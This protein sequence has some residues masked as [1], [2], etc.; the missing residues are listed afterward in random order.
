MKA[1]KVS[2][3]VPEGY[4]SA[5]YEEWKVA[6]QGKEGVPNCYL[7]SEFDGKYVTVWYKTTDDA[8][9]KYRIKVVNI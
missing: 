3:K 2:T 5:D 1:I 8:K 7:F 4:S 9:S 6:Q